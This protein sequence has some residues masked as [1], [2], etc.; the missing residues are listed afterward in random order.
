MFVARIAAAEGGEDAHSV[1]FNPGGLTHRIVD[2]RN[3]VIRISAGAAARERLRGHRGLVL[4]RHGAEVV[5]GEV[6]PQH[7]VSIVEPNDQSWAADAVACCVVVLEQAHGRGKAPAALDG[8]RFELA[9]QAAARVAG[10]VRRRGQVIDL[11]GVEAGAEIVDNGRAEPA[12]A[13]STG[14]QLQKVSGSSTD[15]PV[16]PS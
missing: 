1:A 5:A 10:T 3:I 7:V 13:R 12:C 14:A 4:K 15:G 9:D 16:P 6:E 8:E 2:Q 11:P